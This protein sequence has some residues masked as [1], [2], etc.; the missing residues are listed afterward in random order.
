M[1]SITYNIS[2]LKDIAEKAGFNIPEYSEVDKREGVDFVNVNFGESDK[3]YIRFAALLEFLEKT[4]QVYTKQGNPLIKFDYR[5]GANYMVTNKWIISPNPNICLINP[6]IITLNEELKQLGDIVENNKLITSIVFILSP[7][8]PLLPAVVAPQLLGTKQEDIF[9]ILN[10]LPKFKDDNFE[11]EVGDIMNIFLNVDFVFQI[12]LENIDNKTG[13]VSV[14]KILEKICESINVSLGNLSSITPFIDERTNLLSIIEEGGLPQKDKI[15]DKLKLNKI[16]TPLQLFG[17]NNINSNINSRDASI[18]EPITGV[19]SPTAGFVK[20]FSLKTEITNEL[21]TMIT[22]GAQSSGEIVKGM[23][24]TAFASWN[25]GLIDR[26]IPEKKEINN[27]ED[28]NSEDVE[29]PEKKL[30][31]KYKNGLSNYVNLLNAYNDAN[32]EDDEI[33][34]YISGLKSLIQ[35][36]KEKI[37]IEKETKNNNKTLS[38]TQQGFLPINLN[39][40]LDG[41][42]G[43]V[44][45]Q[46]FEADGRFLPH[47]I[48]DTLTFLTKGISHKISNNVWTT[49][50]DSLSV[51]K[52]V[53]SST[54]T[55]TSNNTTSNNT[56]SNNTPQQGP[57]PNADRLRET[58]TQLKYQEKG[59]E[60]SNG[61]DIT[62]EMADLA[63]AVFNQ[64]SI[65]YPTINII[66]TGGNDNYHQQLNYNSRHKKGNS[67]DFVI[68]PANPTN[69]A[70][71]KKI[72]QGFVAGGNGFVRFLDEYGDP[73]KAA[74]GQHFHLSY[75]QGTEGNSTLNESIALAQN[76]QIETY[77]V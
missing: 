67:I 4:Q 70:N 29:D 66:V 26:V 36:E 47:P 35:Y 21:A 12:L 62:A 76:N 68:L 28:S 69:I 11:G 13:N 32:I 58:L 8:N 52:F 33:D 71:V 23:D 51:P 38:V 48:S 59:E 77:T 6:G 2:S 19:E 72:L 31:E 14:Y 75:G 30:L 17:Y 39:L 55:T 25:R 18:I 7:I 63:I 9:T 15:L 65:S 27:K 22:I 53:K 49:T 44:I 50:I 16:N 3:T 56:T 54:T 5:I 40:T 10:G 34:S 74:T 61:G 1:S 45:L 42:S 64:I 20:S 37:K 60:I 41:I 57:T 24:A 43:P 46:Q 73:T